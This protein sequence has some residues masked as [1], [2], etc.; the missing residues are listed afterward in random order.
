[1][2]DESERLRVLRQVAPG[3]PLREGLENVL[4]A[5]TGGLIV[6]SDGPEVLALASGGFGI[7]GPATPAALYELSK[8][9]GAILLSMDGSRVLRANVHLM[10]DASQPTSE[11]GIR[12]RTAERVSRQTGCLVVAVSQRRRQ[13]TLYK[14]SMRHVLRDAGAVSE[15]ANQALQTLERHSAALEA[16]LEALDRLEFGYEVSLDDV[17]SLVQRA[18][19]ADRIAAEVAGYVVEL[20][21]EGRLVAMQL[22]ELTRSVFEDVQ[23]VL[24]D[25]AQAP[26][27]EHARELLGQLAEWSSEAL[28]DLPAIARSLGYV[29]DMEQ[30]VQ[31][32][33]LRMLRRVPRLPPPVSEKLV[34]RFST[35]Q[36]L[37]AASLE[38]LDEVEGI[39]AARA[40]SIKQH[41]SRFAE[42]AR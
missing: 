20:G 41:L 36:R 17:V 21:D 3:T 8:M 32:R 4:H 6:L 39:G 27:S 7:D 10:P 18:A 31:P 13:I 11:T 25:Y 42:M 24:R 14:G 15:R 40:R 12:H 19:V 22:H 37:M 35:L 1:M 38:D 5:G 30:P 29:G 2:R 33:G 26:L 23:Y 28:L 16:E 9:D 34:E